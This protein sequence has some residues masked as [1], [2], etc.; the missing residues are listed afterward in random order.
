MNNSTNI[1][2]NTSNS[3][4]VYPIQINA[5]PLSRGGGKEALNTFFKTTG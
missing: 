3:K 4:Y 1:S 2:M 5:I